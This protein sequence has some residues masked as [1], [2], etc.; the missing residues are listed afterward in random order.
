M[1]CLFS[2][3]AC[4]LLLNCGCTTRS[5]VSVDIV[6]VR[7]TDMTAFETTATF[8]LRF[9]NESPQP[10]ELTGGAHKIY[11]NN[12]YV[13]KGLSSEPLTVPRLG[14][15]TQNVTVHLNNVALATRLKPIIESQS[16]DYRIQSVL[17]GK[18]WMSRMSS[19]SEGRLDMKDFTPTPETTN[20]P[21]Q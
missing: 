9:S 18:S 3:F 20:A 19:T 6:S 2:V 7:I 21:V 5:T 8:V 16:F 15:A 12:L 1:K 10:V 11:I 13:G 17:Y 14:T 4:V